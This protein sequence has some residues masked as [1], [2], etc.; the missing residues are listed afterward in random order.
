M[1]W[2]VSRQKYWGV[3]PEEANVVEIASGGRDYANP[4]ML[5][6]KY[7]GEGGEYEDPREAVETA[8]EVA[9][10]WKSDCPSLS[11]GVAHGFTAGST[12]PFEAEEVKELKK[13][14]QQAY[15]NLPKCNRCGELLKEGSIVQIIDDPEFGEFCSEYCAETAYSDWQQELEEEGV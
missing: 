8:I 9:Q 6:P 12:M 5:V 15:D 7:Y 14:A 11:I 3:D 10:Q 2:F 13:W 1:P 4:D